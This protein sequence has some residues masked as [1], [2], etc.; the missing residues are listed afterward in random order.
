MGGRIRRRC[1]PGHLAP[2]YRRAMT[3]DPY[4]IT[5]EAQLATLY[6]S[7]APRTRTKI[8]DR[9][10]PGTTGLLGASTFVLLATADADGRCDVSPRGGP[11]GFVK[12]LDDHRVAVPDLNGNHLLDSLQN[13]L[14]NPHAALLVVIP[15]QD[16]T[17]RLE[18]SAYVTTAPDVL[19]LFV[20]E[21]R[22]PTTAVVIEVHTV[23]T[24]CAKAFR[25]G[26][27][28]DAASWA[29]FERSPFLAARHGQLRH[30]GL[31]EESLD[32]YV[33]TNDG[34]IGTDLAADAPI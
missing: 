33:A 30:D 12:V 17:L 14:T 15:G 28:W 21:L 19:D 9:L 4:R 10:D 26:G 22:R 29:A 6:P 2:Q 27:V 8:R 3:E 16:E 32:E 7:P 13:L 23:Y 25:R 34:K 1:A 20:G 24:H 11:S 5:S 31:T 18:G